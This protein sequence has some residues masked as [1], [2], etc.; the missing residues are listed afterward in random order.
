M[1]LLTLVPTRTMPATI[2][3]LSTDL[4]ELL[5]THLT[6]A[7]VANVACV[8]VQLAEICARPSLMKAVGRTAALP[9]SI[10]VR[11]LER[12]AAVDNAWACYRLGFIKIYA[13]RG[14]SNTRGIEL[15]RRAKAAGGPAGAAAAYEL[16][17]C[18]R[19]ADV[20]LGATSLATLCDVACDAS[21]AADRPPAEAARALLDAAAA[22]GSVPALADTAPEGVGRF[23]R[24]K[25]GSTA[26][27][28]QLPLDCWDE[29]TA[30]EARAAWVQV[31]EL[32]DDAEMANLAGLSTRCQNPM[33]VRW[34][35]VNTTVGTGR[36]ARLAAFLGAPSEHKVAVREHG[37]PV[38]LAVCQA[39]RCA[40]YCSPFCQAVHW[41]GRAAT[42]GKL[43]PD[44]HRG[45]CVRIRQMMNDPALQVM[46]A[47][48]P[49]NNAPGLE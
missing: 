18:G 9:A 17:L 49:N 47:T 29:M 40:H 36:H 7:D 4:L 23:L 8:S 2:H 30:P 12:L 20:A 13:W 15:L 45:D 48:N 16:A 31:A 27:S 44:S 24:Q 11:W 39:C 10:S 22:A 6:V 32:N 43:G 25:L 1:A 46:G 42:G 21:A 38:S 34:R 26:E 41:A 14:R 3:D 5:C 28:P 33:C 19:Y 37:P 35:L